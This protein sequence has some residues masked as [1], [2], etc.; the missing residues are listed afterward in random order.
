[1]HAW[2]GARLGDETA[3][4]S[5]RL[6]LNPLAHVDPFATVLLPIL[7]FLANLPVFAAAKPVPF[8]PSR[9]RYGEIGAALV[10]A[11]GPLTNLFLAIFVSLWMRFL[12][13]IS[14]IQDFFLVFVLLNIG[15][16]LFNM[17][18]FPPLDGSR[19]L[20]VI[21]PDPLRRVMQQIESYGL[22][23]IGLFVLLLFYT[24]L[25]SLMGQAMN[26]LM[27]IL[28]PGFNWSTF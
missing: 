18:P 3:R 24:P 23:G 8:N 2:A 10:A 12:P 22:M 7:L 26:G 16:F 5:G 13:V 25:G 20:Y 9:L 14:P 15:L 27:S 1:M 28:V 4:Y 11:S 17:I 19:L 6:S 21:A